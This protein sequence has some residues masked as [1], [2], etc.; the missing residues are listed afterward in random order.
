MAA[1]RFEP[2]GPIGRPVAG[3]PTAFEILEM[4]VRVTG[5]AFRRRAEHGSDVV[6]AFDIRLRCEI[7]IATIRLRLAGE[8][9]LQILFRLR[10]LQI[11]H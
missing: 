6:E 1:F 4:A 11:F 9:V 2:V 8:R 3:S 7:Q 10:A 5:L